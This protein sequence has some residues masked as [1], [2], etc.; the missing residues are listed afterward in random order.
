MQVSAFMAIC[1]MR[2][3][4]M[5]Y[6]VTYPDGRSETV[7]RLPDGIELAA[8]ILAERADDAAQGDQVAGDA[9]FDNSPRNPINPDPTGD[10]TW[11]DQTWQEMMGGFIQ[12]IIDDGAPARPAVGGGAH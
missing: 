2:G 9:H 11:G 5:T 7:F 3:K 12:Y 6:I 10:V 4:D 1:T 8:G